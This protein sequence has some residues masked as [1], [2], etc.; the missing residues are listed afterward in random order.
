MLGDVSD[1]PP[2]PAR[3]REPRRSERRLRYASHRGVDQI[4][5]QKFQALLYLSQRQAAEEPSF[6]LLPLL[7]YAQGYIVVAGLAVAVELD[8]APALLRLG[9]ARADCVEDIASS[10]S[11]SSCGRA[12]EDM[13]D[14]GLDYYE[15]GLLMA[16]TGLNRCGRGV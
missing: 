4:K 2:P 16:P 7:P 13:V 12:C 8:D 10:S 11:S 15:S 6:V 3:Q 5:F 9:D 14:P 1:R